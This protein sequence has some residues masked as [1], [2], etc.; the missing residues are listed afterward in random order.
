MKCVEYNE[1]SSRAKENYNFAKIASRLADYGYACIR[2]T[3]DWD[4]ADFIAVH[5]D[6]P[7]RKVQLK[8]R[9]TFK[10]TYRNK[11]LW[12]AFR[13]EDEIYLFP[14]DKLLRVF[15]RIGAIN[16]KRKSWRAE[17]W[18]S[19]NRVPKKYLHHLARYRVDPSS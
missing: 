14:H 16:S 8:S 12:I 10:K 7:I 9:L 5:I 4:G 6:G 19:W 11:K 2:L 3:D 17:G 1:L 15:L 13:N 18:W